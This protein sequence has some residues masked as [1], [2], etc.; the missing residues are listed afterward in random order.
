MEGCSGQQGVLRLL[1][2]H[3]YNTV[4]RGALRGDR[5]SGQGQRCVLVELLC[6]VTVYSI[7]LNY[8]NHVFYVSGVNS[9]LLF[10]AYKDKYQS[11]DA[12]VGKPNSFL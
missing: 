12:Q 6:I 8:I 1:P 2:A 5:E 7:I 10:M 3:G 11:S 9:F 4:A